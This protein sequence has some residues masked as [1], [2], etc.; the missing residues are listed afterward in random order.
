MED[1]I[2]TVPNPSDQKKKDQKEKEYNV[3]TFQTTS[4]RSQRTFRHPPTLVSGVLEHP[5]LRGE[6]YPPPP[7]WGSRRG[8]AET[9]DPLGLNKAKA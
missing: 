7:P 8:E 4:V 9:S 1:K 6:V 3:E 2:P 5:K